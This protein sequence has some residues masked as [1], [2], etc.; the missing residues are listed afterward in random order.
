L[1][2]LTLH[3]I[4]A[5]GDEQLDLLEVFHRLESLSLINTNFS[6]E[7]LAE[8]SF[9]PRLKRLELIGSKVTNESLRRCGTF[10][11]LEDMQVGGKGLTD[12]SLDFVAQQTALKK[13]SI[14]SF[15]TTPDGLNK[16]QALTQ[17][18]SLGLGPDTSIEAAEQFAQ[19]KPGCKVIH[20]SATGSHE[21]LVDSE[22]SPP[23]TGSR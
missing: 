16:L 17:L 22:A 23:A 3:D 11:Q 12:I 7:R 9:A 10:P 15:T 18:Q 19:L 4:A 5:L 20:L 21:F 14:P 1:R 2:S 13:L 8:L 6:G